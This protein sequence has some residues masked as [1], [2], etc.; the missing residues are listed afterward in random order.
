MRHAAVLAVPLAAAIAVSSTWAARVEVFSPQGDIKGVRQATVRFSEPMVAFGDPRLADPFEVDCPQQGAGRWADQ[1]NWVFDFERDLPAGVRCSFRLKADLKALSGAA[2]EPQAFSF[3]TG[4]P[5]VIQMQPHRY[6][7]VDEEQVFILGLDAPASEDTVRAHAWCDVEGIAERIGVQIVAGEVRRQILDA[8]QDFLRSWLHVLVKDGRLGGVSAGGLE[9]GSTTE[10]LLR[11]TEAQQS[12]VL[13]RCARRLPADAKL[14]LVWGRGIE[15]L[16][17]VPTSQDQ[18][19]QFTVRPSFSAGFTCQRVNA[20]AGCLPFA[21]VQ[22]TFTAPVSRA[23]AERI[24]LRGADGKVYKPKLPDPAHAGEFVDGLEFP[25]PFP[26]EA[27]FRLEIPADLRDDAGRPLTNQK[28]FP[29]PVRTDVAP[30]LAKFPAP[31]GII[32]LNAGGML[33]VTLRNL[34]AEVPGREWSAAGDPA[35]VPG[36]VLRI[37]SANARTVID[38]MRRVRQQENVEYE[39][40]EEAGGRPRRTWAAATSLFGGQDRTRAIRVPKPL[41]ARAFEVVGIPLKRPGFYVVELASPRLGAALLA[42]PNPTQG[43]KPPVYHVSTSAL[44]T[45]LAVHFKHGRETSLVWVTALETGAVVP[46]AR[47]SVQDCNGREYWKG[48]T[49]VRGVARIS[50]ELPPR[51]RLPGCFDEHDRQYMV[52]ARAGGD[53][54]FVLS[55]WDEG[56]SRWRFNLPAASYTGPYIAT[57]VLDRTLLRVAGESVHMKLLYRQHT[58]GGFGFVNRSALPVAAAI[59]HEGSGQRYELPL[60][61]DARNSAELDW[62][63]PRD[64]KTGVY[65]VHLEDSPGGQGNRRDAGSFRVEEFRVPLMRASIE[66]PAQ[67]LVNATSAQLGVQVSY[68][69]G[70]GAALAPVKLRSVVQ[71]RAVSLPGYE[72]FMLMNGVV[73]EGLQANRLGGWY[74]GDSLLADDDAEAPAGAALGPQ[75]KPL[76]T[77][78]FDLDSGGGGKAMLEGLPRLPEPQEIIAELEYADPNGEVLTTSTRIPLWPAALIVGLKP[79]AWALSQ[80]KVKF[81]AVALDLAGKPVAG[82]RLS[83][84]LFERRTFSHRKRLLGGF[85][86]YQSGSEVKRLQR[87]CEGPSDDKGLLF[88][89]FASPVSGELL[90]E[91]RAADRE[92]NVAAANSSVWVAGKGEWWFDVSNDDRMDVLPERKRYEP[93]ETAVFQVRMPFRTATALVTVEREGVMDVQV[94][95]LSGKAPVVKVPVRGNHAPNVFVSV[96]AVRGR[97]ADVQPTALVDLGKPAFRMGVGQ[98]DVGWRAHELKVSVATDRQVYRVRDKAEVSIAVRG[99]LDGKPA[100]KGAE[101]ALAAVDEGLLELAPN[102]SWKLLE[103][104]MQRRGIEVETATASMQVVGKRHYGRKAREPGGGGGRRT[105]R[106]LFDTLLF[107]NARVKLDADGRAS[108]EIPLNDSLTAFRI[109]A[110]ADA[111][112][113]RFGTGQVVIR[114]TQELMLFSG[115]PPLVR[116]QD[117]YRATFT[118]RNASDGPLEI[119][120]RASMVSEAGGA[121]AATEDRKPVAIGLAPGES[122]EVGWDVKAPVGADTLRWTLTASA[123]TAAGQ[124]VEDRLSVTQAVIPAVPVRTVQATMAQLDRSLQ[125]PVEIPSDAIAGRGGVQVALIPTLAGELAGVRDFMR[126]YGYTCLEQLASQAVALRDEARWNAL[127]AN[128]PSYLDRDG[129]A[130]YFPGMGYGSDALTVY[131]LNIANEAGWRI[132]PDAQARMQG[133]L[134]RF[135]KGQ[136]MRDQEWRTADLNVR[137]LAALQA[138]ARW[139][140]PVADG[141]LASVSIEPNLWPTSAVIDWFDLLKR[142]PDLTDRDARMREAE[143]I[144]RSRL[145]FQGTTMGFS[146]ERSDFL[147]WLMISGDVNANRVLLA[148]LDRESWKQDMPRLAR[149]SLGRQ[150]HGRWNTTVANAWGVL[151]MEKFGAAFERDAVAGVTAGKLGSQAREVN[152]GEAPAGKNV[153]FPWPRGPTVLDLSHAGTGKPWAMVQSLA[154]VP[155]RQPFSSG[156]QITRTVS[157]VQQKQA[158]TWSRGDVMRVRLDLEAQ[159]DMT[160]VVVNDPVP[161]GASVLGTGLG[162]DARIL[163]AG[164]RKQGWVWPAFEERKF[165]SF[166][167]YYSFVPRGKWALEYTLRLNN[168]GEFLL[169]PTRVEALYAPEMFGEIPNAKVGV[170]E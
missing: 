48:V 168:P 59:E 37:G 2:V 125:L 40:P 7:R 57:A 112:A 32:E 154:A 148:M 86:A 70:G 88:C 79:D 111:G 141:D 51:N 64:A 11:G 43:G 20:D 106:E 165:D 14:R 94:V 36:N 31:F 72:Q 137:K 58:R 33:P 28:R 34:E 146:T 144:V 50:R 53:V 117:S 24:L 120:A 60:K 30:P 8:R 12:L 118:V 84:D 22:L 152:W 75:S 63:V 77:L 103:T 105:S 131:L 128:L 149:G 69:A 74:R 101:V 1:S 93:G 73:Q 116:E 49:D 66:A 41:G 29:L 132:P 65:R 92:G 138:Q 162:R 52:F 13:L 95:P 78:S 21:P 87:V 47:V 45:N 145:N 164:E 100:P 161:A 27:S 83:V 67:P 54:S 9:R 19:L 150:Q 167:A 82:A 23:A 153:M 104:M 5:A 147:W 35:P 76:K 126:S 160:W 166:R 42:G 122:K 99:A 163:A 158:G 39:P 109:V 61:W 130:M 46:D 18:A 159:S 143:Q 80:D 124:T 62:Q 135:V 114:S 6:S 123:K 91:V 81:Q 26:E 38:W 133:A 119:E 155:L 121:R 4:G 157:A 108:V 151:A 142:A 90:V 127:V 16:S 110:V 129:F 140:R 169:P 44:V 134:E 3:S 25:G 10:Q 107:W 96:L 97:V 68:L 102:H 139:G 71:P 85:Y 136:A 113:D 98:I 17:G 115:L 55:S 15:S 89:E 156:Y 170:E 56:I